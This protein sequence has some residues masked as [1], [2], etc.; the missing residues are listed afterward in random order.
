MLQL[1]QINS[2][3]AIMKKGIG[4]YEIYDQHNF[5]EK[6]GLYPHQIMD[7]KGFTGDSADNYPGVKGIGEKTAIKLLQ[8]YGAAENVLENINQLTK[9]IQNK[10]NENIDMFHLSKQLAE[11][12]C[13]IPIEC[14]LEDAVADFNVEIIEENLN[15]LGIKFRS[16]ADYIA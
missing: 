2:K 5:Y 14:Y 9:G 1:V 13:D 6:K 4:N 15:R 10:L 12:K 11:I 16:I 8:T 7:F 3:V